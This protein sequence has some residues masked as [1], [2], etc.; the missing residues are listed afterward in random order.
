METL[1]VYIHIFSLKAGESLTTLMTQ[2]HSSRA[3]VCRQLW[4]LDQRRTTL[5]PNWKT[6]VRAFMGGKLLKADGDGE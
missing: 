3:P 4:Q 5:P 2:P 6:T 1:Q